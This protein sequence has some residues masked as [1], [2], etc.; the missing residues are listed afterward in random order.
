MAERA[1]EDFL[2]AEGYPSHVATLD[3]DTVI[4][5]RAPAV[6]IFPGK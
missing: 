2:S 3:P 6:D 1:V 5:Q 4:D